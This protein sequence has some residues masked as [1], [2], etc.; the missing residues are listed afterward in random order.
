MTHLLLH[1][2][3][4]LPTPADAKAVH[5][6]ANGLGATL[7]VMFTQADPLNASWQAEVDAAGLPDVHQAMEAEAREKLRPLFGADADLPTIQIRTGDPVR[8]ITEY[9]AEAGID[10]IVVGLA[11][12]EA[13]ELAPALLDASPCSLLVWKHKR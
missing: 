10:L 6:L 4:T 9:A 12:K 3:A 11:G 5:A 13:S 7:H 1:I 2:G 8:S